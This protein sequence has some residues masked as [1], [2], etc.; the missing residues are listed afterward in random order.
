[1]DK[2]NS[3]KNMKIYH[4]SSVTHLRALNLD[5][6]NE[7]HQHS[8]HNKD[9]PGVSDDIAMLMNSEKSSMPRKCRFCNRVSQG[10]SAGYGP[11]CTG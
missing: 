7:S 6:V 11:S 3:N 5:L 9:S 4:S 2:T 10:K 8:L 1:M